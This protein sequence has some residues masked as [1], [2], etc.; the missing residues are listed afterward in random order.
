MAIV[1][2]LS[3]RFH[4]D[5]S[6]LTK[7]AAIKAQNKKGIFLRISIFIFFSQIAATSKITGTVE[8]IC[9][10]LFFLNY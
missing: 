7:V 6:Q 5:D 2:G 8:N 4:N 3:G 1:Y 10:I 9:Q